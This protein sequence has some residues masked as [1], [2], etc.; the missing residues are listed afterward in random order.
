MRFVRSTDFINYAT[1]I[2]DS[3]VL[4]FNNFASFLVQ[5]TREWAS[6][7][8][9]SRNSPSRFMPLNKFSGCM[10]H[11]PDTIGATLQNTGG[12]PAVD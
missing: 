1:D 4:S 8:E 9:G 12:T 7:L 6:H 10:G 3:A 2:F 11:W 5:G